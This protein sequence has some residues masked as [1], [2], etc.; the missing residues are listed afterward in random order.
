M[1]TSPVALSLSLRGICLTITV[2]MGML[3]L[4]ETKVD[5]VRKMVTGQEMPHPVFE[6]NK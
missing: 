2:V 1:D 4:L 5:L 6:V 3:S